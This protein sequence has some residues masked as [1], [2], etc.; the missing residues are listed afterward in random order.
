MTYMIIERFRNGDAVPIYRRFRDQGRMM[1]DG[2]E[3][4]ASWVTDDF[5]TCYQVMRCADRSLLDAWMANWRDLMDFEVVPV[6]PSAEAV[7]A[8]SPRL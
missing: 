4:V 7:T 3:Y 5:S 6:C 2:L 8:I 1:P